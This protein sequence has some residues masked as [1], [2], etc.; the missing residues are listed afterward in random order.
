MHAMGLAHE[1]KVRDARA[2]NPRRP[3]LIHFLEIKCCESISHITA[4]D[5]HKKSGLS[6]MECKTL[7]RV[8]CYSHGHPTDDLRWKCVYRQALRDTSTFKF[9]HV[10]LTCEKSRIVMGPPIPPMDTF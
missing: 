8:A 9:V 5:A 1:G 10:A 4:S 7:Y 3:R 2:S 6:T